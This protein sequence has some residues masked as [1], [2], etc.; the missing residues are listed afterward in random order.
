MNSADD[1]MF[2]A[3]DH[4]EIRDWAEDVYDDETFS[5]AEKAIALRFVGYFAY[6]SD[7]YNVAVTHYLPKTE[8]DEA[9]LRFIDRLVDKQFAE[10]VYRYEN[11][12][13]STVGLKLG[14]RVW[15][16]AYRNTEAA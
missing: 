5:D 15:H 1:W 4:H 16:A 3:I 14:R 10:I 9:V 6:Y 13:H 7:G 12:N 2:L 8:K 11:D